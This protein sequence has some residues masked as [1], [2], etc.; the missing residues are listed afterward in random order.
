MLAAHMDLPFHR[1]SL[2]AGTDE[3]QLQGWLHPSSEGMRFE[4]VPSVVSH[5][6]E[7]GGVVLLDDIDLGD[8]NML[9]IANAALDQAG[10]HIP[11]RH[12]NPVFTKHP[13]F[14]ILAAANTYGHGADRSYVGA[15]QLDERTL[16]RLR[17]G[18][19]RCDYDAELE[20][21]LFGNHKVGAEDSLAFGQRLR[22]RL[23]AQSG[24]SRDVST[25]DIETRWLMLD[26]FTVGEA[27]YGQFCDWSADE[28]ARVHALVDHDAMSVELE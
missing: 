6:Y 20:R 18:Q 27:W 14:Y 11:L 15:N 17:A 16:S 28:C 10:W 23:R 12:A 3:G 24:Q 25:R 5:A 9:G 2:A 21:S 7:H 8:A 26:Q 13:D 22:T 1:V 19:I 4:Y